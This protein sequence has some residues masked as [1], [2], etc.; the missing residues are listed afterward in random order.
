MSDVQDWHDTDALQAEQGQGDP[1]AA[2]VRATR[3]PMIVTDPRRPDNPIVFANAAFLTLTGYAQ[4]EVM[5]RNCRFLQGRDTDPATVS[6]IRAAVEAEHDVSVDILN[7]RKDGT[8][9]WNALYLSPVRTASGEVQFFFASQMDITDRVEVQLYLTGQRELLE[10]EVTR[11]TK[12]LQDA[13]AAKT[14][15]IHEVDHRVKNNLQMIASLLAMQ[16]RGVKDPVASDILK[17]ALQRVEAIGTVHRRLYQSED[18]SR[19]DLSDFVRDTV[20]ETAKATGRS[21]VTLSFDV[22]PLTV[23]ARQASPITL[24]LNELVINALKHAFPDGRGGSLAVS[25]HARDGRLTISMAD[26]GIGMASEARLTSG[27]FGTRLVKSIVRQLRGDVTWR[28]ADPGT[29]VTVSCPLAAI[30]TA[31]NDD[32]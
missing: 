23:P 27:G 25:I 8:P 1:S 28:P 30:E 20:R 16:S 21:D 13:L 9:F 4:D 10:R 24:M 6:T 5:G 14:M 19:F 17:G 31:E 18:V 2:A 15:L 3:M 11:R 32:E 12:D 26:D 29:V 7:Y 22:E